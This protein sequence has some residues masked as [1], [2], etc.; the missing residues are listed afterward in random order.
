MVGEL[1]IKNATAMILGGMSSINE[2]NPLIRD[3][4]MSHDNGHSGFQEIIT[5]FLP[6][7][8]ALLVLMV[9]VSRS[10]HYSLRWLK[11]PLI[12][13]Q[14]ITG[15]LLFSFLPRPKD[16][17]PTT[18][19]KSYIN[20]AN[21]RVEEVL[22]GIGIMF[23]LFIG[24]VKLDVSSVYEFGRKKPLIIGV[25]SQFITLGVGSLLCGLFHEQIESFFGVSV[26]FLMFALQPL[27]STYP[28]VL[29]DMFTELGLLNT[30]LG[31]LA[32][33]SSMMQC[34]AGWIFIIVLNVLAQARVSLRSGFITLV[35]ILVLIT[36]IIFVI[37]PYTVW[38][39]RTTRFNARVRDKH[40]FMI[41][42]IVLAL[43][44]LDDIVGFA[45]PDGAI[46]MGLIMPHGPPLG[47]ALI[48]RVD[49]VTSEL[50]LPL[51]F[52]RNGILFDWAGLVKE[53]HVVL[54][55]EFFVL[56]TFLAK[57]FG[58]A[59]AAK[60]CKMSFK[61]GLLIGLMM[62]FRGLVDVLVFLSMAG[63]LIDKAMFTALVLST[64][65]I[66]AICAPLVSF[67]YEPLRTKRKKG[68]QTVQ[69]VHFSSELRM[70]TCFY[71]DKPVSALIDFFESS[72]SSETNKSVSIYTLHLVELQGSAASSLIL[73]RNNQG[74]INPARMDR[75]KKDASVFP[76]T[77]HSPLKTMHQD[78]CSL[79]L[80]KNIA[81]VIVPYP[82]K[83]SVAALEDDVAMRALVPLVLQQ[84]ILTS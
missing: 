60:Y 46:I 27:S 33:S 76:Y 45:Y 13:C 26:Q 53:L 6:H 84:V 29:C 42:L 41:T 38:I 61:D 55:V 47:T 3:Y 28:V 19:E 59:A 49:L 77:S 7:L 16:T 1:L 65:A 17:L 36:I 24:A 48:E 15:I 5:A 43:T 21:R 35:C 56:I 30:E 10:L 75:N 4:I 68:S 79:I 34:F 70:M 69:N 74:C 20:S 73:H 40:I 80:E 32:L 72:T 18:N 51:S 71:N 11:Q 64:V 63:K 54:G 58:C 62:N 67:F 83:N 50:L 2:M 81:L 22:G 37:R 66:S 8:L 23:N 44:L 14:L 52:M 12:V 31:R 57:L 9:I 78:V 82:R 39:V 25:A